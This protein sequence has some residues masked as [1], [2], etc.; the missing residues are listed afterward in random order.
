MRCSLRTSMSMKGLPSGP[1]LRGV[2]IV[3]KSRCRIIRQRSSTALISLRA[4]ARRSGR[5][6]NAE[7]RFTSRWVKWS[8]IPTLRSHLATAAKAAS[9]AASGGRTAETA[10]RYK[11]CMYKAATGISTPAHTITGAT[12]SFC[13]A[14]R[15]LPSIPSSLTG[16][17]LTA[18]LGLTHQRP[19]RCG[20]MP[21]DIPCASQMRP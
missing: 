13:L 11:F 16:S 21:M 17:T 3:K 2:T 15:T 19:W 6:S 10:F 9:R 8:T 5:Y 1:L 18:K 4:N 7:A 14:D 12:I 20:R